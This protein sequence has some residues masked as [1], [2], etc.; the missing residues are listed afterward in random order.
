[1]TCERC[2]LCQGR[3]QDVIIAFRAHGTGRAKVDALLPD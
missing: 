3:A 2:K 1:M